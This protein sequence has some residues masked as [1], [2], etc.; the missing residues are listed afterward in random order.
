MKMDTVE[1]QK[2]LN[3]MTAIHGGMCSAIGKY[4]DSVGVPKI[5]KTQKRVKL[6]VAMYRVAL[7][8]NQQLQCLIDESD[9]AEHAP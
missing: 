2:E 9:D 3:H 6:L 5:K 7:A 8:E 1:L 4:L